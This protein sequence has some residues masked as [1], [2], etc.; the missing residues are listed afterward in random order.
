MKTVGRHLRE[1]AKRR[2]L[3]LLIPTPEKA[4]AE[5]EEARKA[6]CRVLNPGSPFSIWIRADTEDERGGQE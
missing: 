3:R 4:A 1:L 2:R 6:G 5:I